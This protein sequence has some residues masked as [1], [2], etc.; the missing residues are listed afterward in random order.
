MGIVVYTV[1][2]FGFRL[3]ATAGRGQQVGVLSVLFA[4]WCGALLLGVAAW[5]L[6]ELWNAVTPNPITDDFLQLLDE[7]FG[8]DWR[9]VRRWPWMRLAWAYRLSARRGSV[10]FLGPALRHSLIDDRTCVTASPR[11]VQLTINQ[12]SS[13]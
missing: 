1:G 11:R 2:A 8:A 3:I 12:P 13:C 7:S 6:Y 10:G 5:L 9:S 4:V